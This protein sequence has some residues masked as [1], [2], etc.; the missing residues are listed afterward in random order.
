ACPS[1]PW[2]ACVV[3]IVATAS[4]GHTH[5]ITAKSQAFN[6]ILSSPLGQQVS[7]DGFFPPD[8]HGAAANRESP[9]GKKLNR[10]RID[11]VLDVENAPCERF[12]GIVGR[13]DHRTLQD[14]R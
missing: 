9:L 2:V 11:G 3:R 8:C 6:S 5:F 14:D 10:R 4:S 12:L 13:D 7:R 1:P